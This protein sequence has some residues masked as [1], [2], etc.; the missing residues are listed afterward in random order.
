MSDR[1]GWDHLYLVSTSGGDPVQITHGEYEVRNPSWSTDGSRIVF[2]HNLPGKPGVRYLAIA[3]IGEDASKPAIVDVTSGR[4]TNIAPL[5]SPDGHQVVYQH[6]DPQTS[7]ELFVADTAS[8]SEQPK[9][10]THSMPAGVDGTAFVEP[11]LVSYSAPDGGKVPAYVFVPK[12]LDR[13]RKHPAIVW[14]HGDGINQNYDGWHVER[15]YAVYYSFHQY[16]LQR[17]YVVIAPDYRGSIGYGRE[18]R[19]GVYLDVGGKDSR[20]AAAAADYLKTLSFVDADRIGI[21]GL[22]YG[23]FFTLKALTDRPTTYRCGVDVA[24]VPDFAMWWVD[25]GGPWVNARMGTPKQ[26]PALYSQAAPIDRIEQLSR[27][28]LV[29]HGTS[30]VNVPY[31]ESVRLVDRLLKTRKDFEFMMYPGEFHYFQRTHVLRDAWQRVERFFAS[32]LM[33]ESAAASTRN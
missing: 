10:L 15:N 31:V 4:G 26:H 28:L 30:D 1:D 13:S 16:L 6:T 25:P 7:A 12:G 2:D 11:E 9:R 8:R 24:G 33:P 19:E 21:W 18:W 29:L 23:G 22:S 20:D 3:A 17:G 5:W 32:N 14:V 27:P